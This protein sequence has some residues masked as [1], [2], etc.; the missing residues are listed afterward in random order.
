MIHFTVILTI[1]E[2]QIIK[3]EVEQQIMTCSRR[4]STNECMYLK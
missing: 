2:T 4:G 1:N 3:T